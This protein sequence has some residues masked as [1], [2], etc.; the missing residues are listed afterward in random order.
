MESEDSLSALGWSREDKP[1]QNAR[2]A[3]HAFPTLSPMVV[4]KNVL[5]KQVRRHVHPKPLQVKASELPMCSRANMP[6]VREGFQNVLEPVMWPSVQGETVLPFHYWW[7][8]VLF[9]DLKFFFE[10]IF[11][12]CVCVMEVMY[13]AFL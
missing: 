13:H 10:L 6:S 8:L 7:C 1:R 11:F 3:N 2:A 5:V 4:M 12:K 9:S